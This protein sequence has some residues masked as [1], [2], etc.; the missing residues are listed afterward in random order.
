MAEVGGSVQK[1]HPDVDL[2][3]KRTESSHWSTTHV[4]GVEQVQ[5]VSGRAKVFGVS[6]GLK[7]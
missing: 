4:D 6:Q 7:R 5:N 2:S 1:R 3:V